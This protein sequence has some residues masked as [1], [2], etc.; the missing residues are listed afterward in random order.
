MPSQAE[1][2]VTATYYLMY[3]SHATDSEARQLENEKPIRDLNDP[4]R[5]LAADKSGSSGS[6]A[7]ECR[8]AL[9][10]PSRPFVLAGAR[11]AEWLQR[12]GD[13]CESLRGDATPRDLQ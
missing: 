9:F 7:A 13:G 6:C 5:I 2:P 8:G 3:C 10:G 11:R 4:T 12:F 1:Q